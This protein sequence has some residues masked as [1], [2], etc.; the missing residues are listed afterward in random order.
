VSHTDNTSDHLLWWLS[1]SRAK[2]FLTL[3]H[4]FHVIPRW[5]TVSGPHTIPVY[6]REVTVEATEFVGPH[7]F[8]MRQYIINLVPPGQ[9]ISPLLTQAGAMTFRAMSHHP[10]F[11]TFSKL[12]CSVSHRGTNPIA[13]IIHI[14]PP[15]W[16]EALSWGAINHL[17]STHGLYY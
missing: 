10:V 6:I 4:V 17:A 15:S 11:S 8:Y 2:S 5:T 7:K 3:V 13:I 14:E 1:K 16:E 12:P 9:T